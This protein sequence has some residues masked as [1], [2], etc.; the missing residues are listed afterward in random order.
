MRFKVRS[1]SLC[2]ALLP[3]SPPSSISLPSPATLSSP[4]SL[5][6]T[7]TSPT[8]VSWYLPSLPPS[9]APLFSYTTP[10]F[11][12]IARPE[13]SDLFPLFLRRRTTE[14]IINLQEDLPSS[15]NHENKPNKQPNKKANRFV[16]P[17]DGGR[18][19]CGVGP[20]PMTD[21]YS[22]KLVK[23]MIQ[24]SLRI[25]NRQNKLNFEFDKLVSVIDCAVAGLLFYIIFNAR[26]G[27]DAPQTFYSRVWQTINDKLKVQFCAIGDAQEVG[28]SQDVGTSQA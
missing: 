27:D 11:A 8:P 25:Y 1:S 3:V 13:R 4:A 16:P 23:D 17:D 21:K 22:Q 14:P 12:L 26:S 5:S 6:S 7:A 10:S 28:T 9:P 24:K 19:C 15:K 20:Y 18:M 2:E